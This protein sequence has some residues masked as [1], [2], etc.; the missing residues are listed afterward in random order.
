M[1]WFVTGFLWEE[2]GNWPSSTSWCIRNLFPQDSL[3]RGWP[4]S[5]RSTH[6]QG[7]YRSHWHYWA[8]LEAHYSPRC[9]EIEHSRVSLVYQLFIELSWNI[10]IFCV[11]QCILSLH[12]LSLLVNVFSE[13]TSW[14]GLEHNLQSFLTIKKNVVFSPLS[15]YMPSSV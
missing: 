2:R 12:L 10:P 5:C 6:S 1:V 3:Y 4:Q 15:F 8:D 13:I 9:E 11:L 14:G 7:E